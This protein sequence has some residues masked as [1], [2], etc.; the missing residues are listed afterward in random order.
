[1]NIRGLFMVHNTGY[2]AVAIVL[3]LLHCALANADLI[4]T[5]PPR[6]SPAAGQKQYGPLA[7][8]LTRVLG[9][10]VTYVQP[11]GWLYYQRDMRLDKYDIIFDGPHFISWRV[12]QFNQIPVAKLPGT[13]SFMVFTKK[14]NTDIT[15][16]EDLYNKPMCGIAPP[17][18]ATLTVFAQYPNPVRQPRLVAVKGGAPGVYK[19]FKKGKCTTAVIRDK[20]YMK[21]IP[22]Q[23]RD[24][25]KV[26][27]HS[28][29][30]TNQGISVSTRV[31]PE[32]REK[33]IKDLTADNNA[34]LMP[35]LKRF[36]GKA[37]KMIPTSAADYDQQYKLL[38]GIIFGWEITNDDTAEQDKNN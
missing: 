14:S 33:I 20:Y 26:I 11:K 4:L 12:K 22:E 21:K 37:K 27:F 3:L 16:L 29:P 7:K 9:E 24:K 34:A 31:T 32:Q 10:K 25:L 18:L 15:K 6:E 28:L 5:A 13:L 17:N 2:Q 35:T 23:E 8:Q 30:V 19:A 36:G 38:T 1:M